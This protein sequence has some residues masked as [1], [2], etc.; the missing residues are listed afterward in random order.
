MLSFLLLYT[1]HPLMGS[2]VN[3]ADPDEMNYAAF[4]QGL[5]CFALSFQVLKLPMLISEAIKISKLSKYSLST[6]V[7]N[8]PMLIFEAILF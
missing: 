7:I 6:D 8:I 4:H 5:H 1:G 3:N 2:L